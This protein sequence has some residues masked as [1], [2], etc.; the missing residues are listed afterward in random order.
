V[1]QHTP[2]PDSQRQQLELPGGKLAEGKPEE[3]KTKQ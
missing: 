1:E 2:E 3:D